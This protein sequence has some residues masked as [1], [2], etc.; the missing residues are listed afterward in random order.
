[1]GEIPPMKY[2]HVGIGAKLL[3]RAANPQF[4]VK[5]LALQGAGPNIRDRFGHET[6][7]N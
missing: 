2:Q 3:I 6:G 4:C 7:T 5:L 1:M